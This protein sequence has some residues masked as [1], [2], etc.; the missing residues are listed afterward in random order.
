MPKKRKKKSLLSKLLLSVGIPV[1]LIFCV[2]AVIVLTNVKQSV[3]QL[4]NSELVDKSQAASQEI[5]GYFA[6]YIEVA[7]QMAANSQFDSTFTKTTPG[8]KITSI[9]GFADVKKTLD[10][11]QQTDPDNIV[12]SWI[13]DIDSSQLTQSDGYTSGSDWVVTERPWYKEL[14]AKQTVII[15]EPYQDTQT[16]DWIVSV[17]APVY[18]PGTKN[19]AGAT[20]IDF[21]LGKLSEMIQGYKLGNTGFYM[22]ST[23]AGQLI[24]HPDSSIINKNVSESNMSKNIIDAISN[25]TVGAITYTAMKGTNYGYV[26]T[27]GTT[28]WT[29]TT[30]M[31][32]TEFNSTYNSVQNTVFVVFLIAL[33]VLLLIL[34]LIAGSIIRPLKKLTAAAQQIADGDL[35]VEVAI[36][37]M[38]ETGQVA[39]AI[40]QTVDRLKQYINY[41]DEVSAVLD[42][43][44]LGNLV[45]ELR[46][47]Y[48]GEFSKIKTSLE[49][50]KS[51]LVKTFA[52]ITVSADQVAS[53]ADQ[54]A[55]ASQ[56]LAQGAT[57]QASSIEELS[58]SITEIAGQVNRNAEHAANASQL[59]NQ[60]AL[61]VEHGNQ[62]MMK[63]I[64]A[65]SEISESSSEIGKIIKTIEDIAFQTNILALN[66]AVE[67]A[68]AGAAGKGF[69]VVADEVRNLASK[70]AEAAKNT[71]ALIENSVNSVKN[72]TEIANETAQSLQ[73]IIDGVKKTSELIGEISKA[74]NEQATSIN[75]V[76]LGV[77][78]ISAVVQTN[79][80]TSEE[81][82]ASREE[83]SGQAQTLKGLVEQFKI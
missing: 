17:V 4:A 73:V 53:G 60:A 30:G 80:A 64:G 79:S 35:D 76:T 69:A 39:H 13:A 34:V 22:L 72:G 2:T 1:A 74:T 44:A 70:S 71:T 66:A 33:F 43:I 61:E 54:V 77:D 16:K 36:K 29:V 59:S 25:K 26:S 3:N 55:G 58:A 78:Q 40:S 45:F 83:L 10:A 15:T 11:V 48:V 5:S 63:L 20:A 38:D 8:T 23:A 50:I 81:S 14:V 65:M 49:N 6:K 47:D 37:S 18:Q 27:I 28:G 75:Q 52:D 31:P 62:S 41:I 19:I 82:A 24:Y 46:Y 56:G 12:V 57:E 32:E 42:Q 67:A 51:T 68:R 9:D 7:K 21:K